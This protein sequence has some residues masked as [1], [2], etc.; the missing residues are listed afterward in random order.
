MDLASE[1]H[2]LA[3]GRSNV[4]AFL[5]TLSPWDLLYLRSKFRRGDISI[6]GLAGLPDLPA[7]ILS[8]IVIQLTLDDIVNCR[9]VSRDWY[10][11]WTQGAV[12]TALGHFFFPGLIER[13][14]WLNDRQLPHDLVQARRTEVEDQVWEGHRTSFYSA[15]P[16]VFY[17]RG[18]LAWQASEANIVVDDLRT[19][20][21]RDCSLM[22][23]HL[24]GQKFVLQGMSR[25]MLV[26]VVMRV[27]AGFSFNTMKIWHLGLEDWRRVTLPG[28]VARCFVE[29][30]RAAFITRQG[31]IIAWSWNGGA[32]EID[33]SGE[34]SWPL[35]GYERRKSLPGVILHPEKPDTLYVASM[36]RSRLS[37]GGFHGIRQSQKRRFLMSVVRYEGSKPL[38]RWHEVI[39]DNSLSNT[40]HDSIYISF[41]ITLLCSKMSPNGLYNLGTVLTANYEDDCA[42]V[43]E[44]ATAAF[45]IY[46]EAFV[47]RKFVESDGNGIIDRFQFRFEPSVW[48]LIDHEELLTTWSEEHASIPRWM[49]VDSADRRLDRDRTAANDVS[50]YLKELSTC[51][52]V[53]EPCR[54]FGDEDF[55]I[56]VTSQGILVWSFTEETNLTTVATDGLSGLE[57]VKGQP[58][59][60]VN[61]VLTMDLKP[62][63][64]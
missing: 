60:L 24:Q 52:P 10:A 38:R 4:D 37:A 26:F 56:H 19:C 32:T 29:G 36:F 25:E 30:E 9:L 7:E 18:C 20:E 16:P 55:Q 23:M 61:P 44:L 63:A 2:S 35:E 59:K 8:L 28:P 62:F 51:V 17:D 50:L 1:Q 46:R 58:S 41:R 33:V 47:Q 27:G 54:I 53:S 39:H 15:G 42:R 14:E 22:E 43:V 57:A 5:T 40:Y 21:R 34:S 3:V 13:S 64:G 48:G 12:I 11:T 49:N 6:T 45:N 31:L